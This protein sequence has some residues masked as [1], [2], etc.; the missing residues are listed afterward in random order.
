MKTTRTIT[1]LLILVGLCAGIHAASR[2]ET[3]HDRIRKKMKAMSHLKYNFFA[4]SVHIS[5]KH[6]DPKAKYLAYYNEIR[7]E[8]TVKHTYFCT[9]GFDVG[10]FGVQDHG[11]G[12][13]A[14]FSVWDKGGGKNRSSDV[15][16]ADR[17][18]VLFTNSKAK[19]SRFG[20]EG[21]GAKTMMPYA[22]KVGKVYKFMVLL[23][24]LEKGTIYT[25]W[26]AEKGKA[27]EK[28]A[29]Y[30]TVMTKKEIR[31]FYSF[32]EDYARNGETGQKPRLAFYPDHGAMTT[33]GKW[34]R[35]VN[36][37]GS[38]ADDVIQNGHS[39]VMNNTF[40]SQSGADT[41]DYKTK[42]RKFSI[43]PPKT[44][45]KVD[46]LPKDFEPKKK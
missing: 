4:P 5:Y 19:S 2:R 32:L 35:I 27:W 20:G 15:D 21:S 39:G 41:A 36:G 29:S 12:H 42:P 14:I 1:A 33:T 31:G 46:P 28:I 45:F 10:Y 23:T 37:S 34:Q 30:Q 26:V 11:S 16:Q 43:T 22:W 8:K 40:Y 38:I 3:R 25:A 17:T 13:L 18:K 6:P 24:P 44:K 7:I 9:I